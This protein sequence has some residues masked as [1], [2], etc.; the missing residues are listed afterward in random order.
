MLPDE[1]IRGDENP[2]A[3]AFAWGWIPPTYWDDYESGDESGVEVERMINNLFEDSGPGG[4]ARE[5]SLWK[6]ARLR[7]K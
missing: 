2:L 4:E 7:Y 5:N 6:E 3:P 1:S